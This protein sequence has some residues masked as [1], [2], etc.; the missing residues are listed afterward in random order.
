MS[1]PAAP[2]AAGSRTLPVLLLLAVGSMLGVTA[3]IAKAAALAGWPP[4]ALLAW[5]LLGGGLIQAGVSAAAGSGLKT[6]APYLRYYLGSGLLQALP[7]ALAFAATQHVG[8][9]IVALSFAFPLIFTYAL[10]LGFGLERLQGWRLAGVLLGLAGGLVIAAGSGQT[11]LVPSPWVL[12]ALAAPVVIA[13]GNLY[14]SLYW[15]QGATALELAP[16][17]LLTAGASL[18]VGLLA[19]DAA[20]V[21]ST[22][23]FAVS[24]LLLGQTAIFA[25]LFLLYFVLQKLAGPVYLSQIGSVGALVGIALATALLDEALN[26]R[27][28]AAGLLV[29]GGIYLVNRGARQPATGRAAPGP[30]AESGPGDGIPEG[31]RGGSGRGQTGIVL[32]TGP[33]GRL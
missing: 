24:A 33:R 29:G 9:G 4:V 19:V 31:R 1:L 5:A 7:N 8:A 16:G 12:A 26:A 22:W 10:A 20:L 23:S 15:P 18:L 3:V 30:T 25:L 14:R 11:G 17:M 21:P 27:V 28:L 6:G 2:A 32:S 13:V